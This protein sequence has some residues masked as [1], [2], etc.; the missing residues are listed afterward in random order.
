MI[1]EDWK[2]KI[3]VLWLM[4]TLAGV[5]VGF[6]L[7]LEPGVLEEIIAG[8]ISGTRITPELM[9]MVSIEFLVPFIM[10]F[11]SLT[12]KDSINRWINIIVGIVFTALG[13][14]S[15]ITYLASA[16]AYSAYAILMWL[17]ITVVT[18]LIVWYAWR[19]RQKE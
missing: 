17:S 6:V 8:E 1:I 18:A 13:L 15:A 7:W 2:I 16:S 10:A 3:S 9:L 19:S 5:F 14:I 4:H 12:L 11:L